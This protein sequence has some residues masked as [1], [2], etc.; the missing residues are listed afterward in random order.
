MNS[1]S[2]NS[3]LKPKFEKIEKRKEKKREY[4][5]KRKKA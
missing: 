1:T 5:R 3:N 2:M 4:K